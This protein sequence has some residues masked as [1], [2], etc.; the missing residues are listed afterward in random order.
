MP[1]MFSSVCALAMTTVLFGGG[2]DIDAVDAGHRRDDGAQP[3]RRRRASRRVS[4]NT[5][6]AEQDVDAGQRIGRGGEGVAMGVADDVVA[7]LAQVG[8]DLVEHHVVG[9]PADDA[10]IERSLGLFRDVY[11]AAA[12][13]SFSAAARA[14]SVIS[15]P[16]SMRAI[17]SR[18]RGAASSVT[19]VATRLPLSSASLVMR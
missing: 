6:D 7:G 18:R 17:S 8:A 10:D 5:R 3:R 13:I 9:M 1:M 11:P 14:S 4:G 19:R 12:R 2:R 16:A 15:A